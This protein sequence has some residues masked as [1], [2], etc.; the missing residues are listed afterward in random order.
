M[1]SDLASTIK[2]EVDGEVMGL[3]QASS[4]VF[5]NNREKKEACLNSCDKP[6]LGDEICEERPNTR[7]FI[8]LS[9][10]SKTSG[11]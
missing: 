3:S 1:Y 11:K 8:L 9:F 5:Q 4:L 7:P 10:L 6:F 2:T